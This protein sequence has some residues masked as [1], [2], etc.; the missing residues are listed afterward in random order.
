MNELTVLMTGVGAPGASSILNCLRNNKERI[1]RI[2]GVDMNPQA[3]CRGRVDRFYQVPS[4]GDNGFIEAVRD[5]CA[6]ES[7]QVVIPIVT[8]E[9]EL[10]AKNKVLFEQIGTKVS[11]MDYEPLHIANNKGL[12]LTSMKEAGYPTADFKVVNTPAELEKAIFELGY[13]D[14]P[15]VV[16]PTI[17]NGSRGT[18]ILD[19]HKSRYH[20]LFFEKPNSQ[21]MRVEELMAIINEKSEIP[22]MIVMEYLPGQE[23]CVD[24]LADHGKVLYIS[25]RVGIAVNSIM[26]SNEVKLI[27]DAIDL[28]TKVVELL[29]LEGNIDF[30]MKMNK[31]GYPHILEINPRLP[32]G[33]AAQAM[34]GMN[35]PY[36]RIKQLMGEKMPVC[37]LRQGISMQFCNSELFFSKDGEPINW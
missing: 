26:I 12:L 24:V 25:S 37:N 9:L 30:D 2:I 35:L 4:A 23:L 13:P 31:E 11:V 5:I 32:A 14:K 36:L 6:S 1:L 18:R 7:V 21:N 19:A 28:A 10:F 3:A 16:K 17:G 27:P 8:R 20:Q 15:V 34:A 22:E 29:S 33:V